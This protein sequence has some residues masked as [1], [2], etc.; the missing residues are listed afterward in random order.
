MEKNFWFCFLSN[1]HCCLLYKEHYLNGF[2][3]MLSLFPAIT[4]AQILV[5]E[6]Q[7]NRLQI[8]T[9]M[10]K[11]K[12]TMYTS[13]LQYSEQSLTASLISVHQYYLIRSCVG[14][15]NLSFCEVFFLFF[16]FL[17]LFLLRGKNFI[18]SEGNCKT[19]LLFQ[20]GWI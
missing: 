13:V 7:V 17:L 2:W 14:S 20:T 6:H 19:S 16:F 9:S 15:I 8:T 10:V 18:L 5:M 11:V 1:Y 4:N 12:W 3:I